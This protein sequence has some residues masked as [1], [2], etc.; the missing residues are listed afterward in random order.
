MV[1]LT[2]CVCVE[3]GWG[4]SSRP[5]GGVFREDEEGNKSSQEAKYMV[6]LIF[7]H[8]YSWWWRSSARCLYYQYSADVFFSVF[9]HE[10]EGKTTKA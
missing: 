3:D 8:V 2:V 5:R 1:S 10:K 4:E 9:V 7:A 6:I